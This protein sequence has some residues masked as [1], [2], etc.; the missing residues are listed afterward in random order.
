MLEMDIPNI[1]FIAILCPNRNQIFLE[2][3]FNLA[4]NRQFIW[5]N[6]FTTI[7]KTCMIKKKRNIPIIPL[8]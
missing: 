7:E 6:Y 2:Y 4:Y 8:T 5:I 3:L 1:F